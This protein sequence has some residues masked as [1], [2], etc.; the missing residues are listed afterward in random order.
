MA[1]LLRRIPVLLALA[2]LDAAAV[3]SAVGSTPACDSWSLVSAMTCASPSAIRTATSFSP[4]SSK[5]AFVTPYLAAMA[6]ATVSWRMNNEFHAARLVPAS[7]LSRSS[8]LFLYPP[9]SSSSAAAAPPRV[10]SARGGRF[11]GRRCMSRPWNMLPSSSSIAL[12]AFSGNAYVM[13]AS[14]LLRLVALS[15]RMK[16]PVRFPYGA[17]CA[18][19]S[20][21]VA[22]K[23]RLRMN[24]RP[25]S[26]TAS[27]SSAVTSCTFGLSS[28]AL[29]AASGVSGLDFSSA[30]SSSAS[31]SASSSSS[32]SSSDA[33]GS[34]SRSSIP[35]MSL[36]TSLSSSFLSSSL[37]SSSSSESESESE[38]ESLKFFAD[39]RLR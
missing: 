6:A 27:M 39:F 37:S 33:P 25:V 17:K 3:S 29:S 18:A 1:T 31:S 14:P 9:A 35:S 38:S 16:T 2:P 13:Y 19:T 15:A 23:G 36:S 4:L 30:F 12:D 26:A 21:S 10:S 34:S 8:R 24:R 20:S 22:V 28:L 5:S 7:R 11:A 32:S